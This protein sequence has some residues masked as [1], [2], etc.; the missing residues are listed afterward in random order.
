MD[1]KQ[2]YQELR[3]QAEQL[4]KSGERK[5]DIENYGNNLLKLLEE[6][7]IYQI[8]LELQNE[9]LREKQNIID[10]EKEKFA[11]LYFNAP[12]GY[13]LLNRQ[14]II[15]ESNNKAKEIIAPYQKHINNY[16]FNL[17]LKYNNIEKFILHL[18]EVF[19]NNDG[20]DKKLELFIEH[21]DKPTQY[22]RLNSNLLQN[23]YCRTLIEDITAEKEYQRAIDDLNNRLEASMAAGN[24]AWWEMELP[25]GFIKFN[26]T[27]TDVLNRRHEDFKHYEDFMNLVHPDDYEPAMEAMRQHMIGKKSLY[28]CEYRIKHKDGH[29]LWFHDIGRIIQHEG[30]YI[31]LTGIVT[32]ITEKKVQQLQNAYLSAL[33]KNSD[34]IIVVKDKNLKV[35]A[36]NQAYANIVGKNCIEEL[37]GKTDAEI[38]GISP[39]QEPIKSYMED[40]LKA[41]QLKPGEAIIKEEIVIDKYNNELTYYTKK[42]PI[43]DENGLL[44]ATGNISVDITKLKQVEKELADSQKKY[45]DL[46][47]SNLD[48]ITVFELDENG[49]PGYFVDM[50]ENAAK[51]VGYTREEILQKKPMDLEYNI[52]PEDYKERGRMLREYGKHNFETEL[53]RKDG[54][55]I[56]TEVIAKVIFYN[57]KPAVLNV[58]RDITEKNKQKEKINTH[59]SRTKDLLEL[60]QMKGIDVQELFKKSLD[61]ATKIT[62]SRSGFVLCVNHLENKLNL[63]ICTTDLVNPRIIV[64]GKEEV[65]LTEFNEFYAPIKTLKPEI[66][67][68]CEEDRY[69]I[70][71]DN[72]AKYE[73]NKFLALPVVSNEEVISIVVL[74]NKESDYHEEDILQLNLLFETV[75]IIKKNNDDEQKI[76]ELLNELKAANATKDKFFSIIAH[77]LKSPF[78]YLLSYS[79]LLLN[80]FE[81]SE[82]E[83]LLSYIKNIHEVSNNTYKLLQNLLEWSRSQTGKIKYEPI[84][85]DFYELAVN[86]QFIHQKLSEPKSIKIV[87]RVDQ[88]SLLT[89]DYH[90]FDTIMRNLVSNA[91]KFSHPNSEVIIDFKQNN[92]SIEISVQD[93]GLGMDEDHI[94]KLFKLEESITKVGT[95]GE[96]G[97]G[98]GLI[99]CNEFIQYHKGQLL[100]ES[101]LG[102]GTTFRIILPRSN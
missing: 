52:T 69:Y 8:E 27:K 15:I 59:L 79:E 74:L 95:N 21:N 86:A 63:R 7:S 77:D 82:K 97:T 55:T 88:E 101:E 25:S 2:S 51:I 6:L 83:E 67:N 49:K 31:K 22:L 100:V 58:A 11:D 94:S 36:T 16:P 54:T 80:E 90:M 75:W 39:D 48:S 46:F 37:L 17:Y 84:E 71:D 3:Q 72:G 47:E 60:S 5:A 70:I 20:K 1:K 93:F 99:L 61:I 73:I 42:Y 44:L 89:G 102:K 87:S 76:R 98:L 18:K 23:Q 50:N 56:D 14:G 13:L 78:T 64:D 34:N 45:R 62:K 28:E 29:Y 35:I 57:G 43:Y 91:I 41:Q 32:N 38:F 65:K 66:R 19:E 26:R 12:V 53:I 85:F 10:S 30:N 96:R 4:I 9:E 40:E 92:D 81:T 24:M 33:V 68:N